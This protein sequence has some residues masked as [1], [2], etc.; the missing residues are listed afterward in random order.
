MGGVLLQLS[1]LLIGKIG[2]AIVGVALMLIG[3]SYFTNM[4]IF[5]LLGG[6]K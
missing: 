6:G 5:D 2:G 1:C 4:K 3:F